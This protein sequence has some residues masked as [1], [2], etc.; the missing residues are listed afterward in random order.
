MLCGFP[1]VQECQ[2]EVASNAE[3]QSTLPVHTSI[4]GG[5]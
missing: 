2:F 5:D 3:V 1:L 4:E